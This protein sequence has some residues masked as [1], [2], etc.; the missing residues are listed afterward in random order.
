M[1]KIRGRQTPGLE[2]ARE[3]KTKQER[4]R[5]QK[6]WGVGLKSS[7]YY[8][9]IWTR[10]L[11]LYRSGS[12][13]EGQKKP[14]SEGVSFTETTDF[15][16]IVGLLWTHCVWLFGVKDVKVK[17]KLYFKDNKWSYILFWLLSC[18][19]L[20]RLKSL[21]NGTVNVH[22]L[23]LKAARWLFNPHAQSLGSLFSF[24]QPNMTHHDTKFW[25]DPQTSTVCV[26][27]C[28]YCNMMTQWLDCVEWWGQWKVAS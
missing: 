8:Y 17:S 1:E 3:N 14:W 12:L 6:R 27:Q 21:I 24:Q 4:G 9:S 26:R 13:N 18:V 5:H 28:V 2:S 23:S 11:Q 25:S 19:S 16:N 22:I 10:Q 20:D 7:R 15:K